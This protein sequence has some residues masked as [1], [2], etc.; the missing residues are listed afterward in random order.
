MPII[1]GEKI[2]TI[3][4]Q[5][6]WAVDERDAAFIRS[7]AVAQ[8]EAGADVIDV[9]VGGHPG[10][11][12]ETMHWAVEA[13]QEV[14]DLPLAIDSSHPETVC[15]GLQVCRNRQGAWANSI[16][17]E[18]ARLDGVLPLV[19]ES[20]CWVVGLCMDEGG[21]PAIPARRLEMARRLIDEVERRGVSRERLYLDAL[22]EPI[23][24]NPAAG[25]IALETIK[26]I[27]SELPAAKTVICLSAISFGLPARR[28]LNRTYLPL[29][30]GSGVDAIF[31]DPL[32]SRLMSALKAAQ[33]LLGR[34]AHG[35][36]YIAAYRSKQLE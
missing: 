23:S 27:R 20:G 32:D 21:V 19:A 5:V 10:Q 35:L 36:E 22:I 31:L 14:V 28:L 24:V 8:A 15:A 26:A 29:L 9:N 33:A 4:P 3:N 34:D 6:R 13:I 7:L 12:P 11:E 30:I 17:L 18:K 2:N 25:L 16:T 1:I